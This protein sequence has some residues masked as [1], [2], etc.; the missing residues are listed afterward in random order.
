MASESHAGFSISSFFKDNNIST[1]FT[2]C[3][4]HISPI[5]VG[6]ESEG[7]NI[8][9]VRDEASAVFAADATSRITDTIGVAIVTAGPGVTNTMTAIKNAQLAQSPLLLIGGAA[10]TLLKGKGSLQDIDQLSLMKPHVKSATS[11]KR[12]RDI[13]PVLHNAI[14][15][16]VSDVPGPV[17]VELP[18]DLLYPEEMIR[19]QHLSQISSNSFVDKVFKWYVE[20]HLKN[21]FSK[22]KSLIIPRKQSIKN[23]NQSAIDKAAIT[24]HESV[25]P[26]VLLGNQIIHNKEF[27][28]RFIQSLKKLSIP[29]Y[30]SGMARGCLGKEDSFFLRHNRKHA[31]KNADVVITAGVPLD[32]RLGYGFSINSNAKI[33]AL[34][35]SRKDLVKN[36]RPYLQLKGD[37]SRSIYEIAKIINTPD[38][39]TW[40]EELQQMEQKRDNEI[41]AQAEMN[42]EFVNPIK[43]C[44]TINDVLDENS[45]IIADGGDFV[46]TA[47][48]VLRP[49]APLS[50]LDPGAFGTLGVGG[51]FALGAK[52]AFPNKEVWIIY[53]D[54][55]CAFSLAEFDTFVRHKLPVIAIVGNDSSWQQIAREQVAML[56]SDI[57]TNLNDTNYHQVAEGYGGK[58]FLV[59][60][61]SQLRDVLLQAKSDAKTGTPVLI[62]MRIGKT[63]FRKGSISI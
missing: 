4:G 1:V 5:L 39:K 49:R 23:A 60:E 62:N 50:W 8:V 16:A 29:T 34:N 10:A 31:L 24:I 33:I 43:A 6:C 20:Q 19:E 13:V 25:R 12:C 58:G 53:G 45:I 30:T 32:F 11:V 55:A 41:L 15:R 59:T 28:D 9:Q 14:N 22:G 51:G 44:T 48:Y 21:V 26:V 47:S 3:G 54:G 7:I 38:C 2:L 37:P 27:L 57:G 61:I 35:K 40:L 46:G 52:S 17:F 63:D 56:G 42:T 18:I 36:R